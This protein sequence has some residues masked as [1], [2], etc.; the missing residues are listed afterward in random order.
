MKTV[1]VPMAADLLH[2]G[3]MNVLEVARSYGDVT[4]GLLTDKAIARYKR[5]PM[6]TY[7]QRKR[8][9]ENII[10]VKDVYAQDDDNYVSAIKEIK[11]D[12]FV[13]GDD[14]KVGVQKEKR[15]KVIETMQEW[16]GQVIEPEY[17]KGIS[18]TGMINKI[19]K[20]GVAPEIRRNMLRRLLSAKPITRILETH[21]G[22]T[23]LIV[24]N[25]VVQGDD[26]VPRTFDG[27]WLS[28]LTH[29][30]SKGKPDIQYVDI[31]NISHTVSEIFEVTTKPMIVDADS[32][33]MTEHFRLT[34][35]NLER[36]GVSAV[37]IEDKVGPKRN[38]LFGTDVEQ[39]Q[40]SIE[41]FSHKISEGKK[42]Q[43]TPDFMIIARIESLILK[44]GLEDALNRAKAYIQAGADAL[45][46]HS[47]EK[48]PEEILAFCRRFKEFPKRVPLVVVPST[49][50]TI[51]EEELAQEGVS[52][53]I[54]ANHLLRSA[55][56]A[57]LKTAESILVYKRCHEANDH[58]LGIKDIITLIPSGEP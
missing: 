19:K 6:L 4:V 2:E 38:S 27:M 41:N 30:T 47:K 17:T 50:S 15:K 12:F 3:H 33:G 7:E 57:M 21:N 11:P 36:I 58:C 35:R 51:T 52:M 22:L 23:G 13:H 32:G 37:I 1:Y 10:G 26:H 40:D 43:I 56:P 9:I 24:E 18:T 25:T 55:Y 46:I 44:K 14:W 29:A 34:V 20:R 42:A 39:S 49:Y 45:M 8:V 54:Y 28:S 5:L 31:T 48:T 53:V 16:G